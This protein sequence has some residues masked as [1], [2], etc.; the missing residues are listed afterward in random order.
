ME[1]GAG[2]TLGFTTEVRL[3][4]L[5]CLELM[6]EYINTKRNIIKFQNSSIHFPHPLDARIYFRV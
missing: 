6:V 2:Q 5:V 3:P 4:I 1:C